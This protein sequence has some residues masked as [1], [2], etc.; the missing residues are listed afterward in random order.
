MEAAGASTTV[1]MEF[2]TTVPVAAQARKSVKFYYT[3]TPLTR[4]L[5]ETFRA[6]VNDAIGICIKE[7]V[8]GRLGL[9]NRIYKEFQDRYGVVSVLPYSVAEVAWSIVKKHRRWQRRPVAK[10]LMMKMDAQNYSLTY[11]ILS[12]PYRRGE[13]VMIPLRY[14]NYQRSFLIG[15]L[16]RGSVTLTERAAI[17]CFTK[18]VHP[19]IPVARVGIDLNEKSAVLSDGTKYDLAEVARLHTEYGIR[20]RDFYR[21]HPGDNRLRKKFSA[22]SREKDR[23]RQILHATAKAIV[24]SAKT[25]KQAITLERLGGIRYAHGRGNWEPRSKR[26]RIA[27]WPFHV[28]QSFIFYKA[29]WVGVQVQQVSAAWTSQ[30]CNKCHRVNTK[31]KLTEREWR[32]PTCGAILDRDLN[33]AINIERRGNIPCLGEV[34]PGAQGINEAV[35][36]NEQTATPILRA[37]V[38]KSTLS[39]LDVNLKAGVLGHRT[40]GYKIRPTS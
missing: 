15:C 37:E 25:R 8:K 40:S 19:D 23:V 16:K 28:L 34:R 30:T 13:R 18:K 9:R 21:L 20:R 12:L 22:R 4:E 35:K 29:A 6:M 32:C 24:D 2:D 10:R 11:A 7:N 17:V 31:L 3:P 36:G 5:L 38:L 27:L 39:P 14:G 26:R 33:A 1:A